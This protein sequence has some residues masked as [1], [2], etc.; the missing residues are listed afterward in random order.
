[1]F[2]IINYDIEP[3]N[4]PV[5]NLESK[6]VQTGNILSLIKYLNYSVYIYIYNRHNKLPAVD[7]I[8]GTYL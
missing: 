5:L 2:Y 3:I 4:F 7:N 6:N 1:M 8:F